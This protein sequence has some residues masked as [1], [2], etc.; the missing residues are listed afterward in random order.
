MCSA[1]RSAQ[2]LSSCCKASP[3][4]PAPLVITELRH[5]RITS[6]DPQTMDELLLKEAVYTAVGRS[7]SELE[8]YIPFEDWLRN[9]L[10][11]ECA[12]TDL[13]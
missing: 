4:S 8:P 12:G 5:Q 13:T 1:R 9:T 2:S 6:T 3:V 11:A 10:A 7:P